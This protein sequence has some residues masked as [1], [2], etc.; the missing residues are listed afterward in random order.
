MRRGMRALSVGRPGLMLATGQRRSEVGDLPWREI[1]RRQGPL[2]PPQLHERSPAARILVPLS[3]LA[4][5]T[6]AR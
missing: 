5:V 4:L 2:D 6:I 3:P 1:D